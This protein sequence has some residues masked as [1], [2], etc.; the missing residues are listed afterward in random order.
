MAGDRAR[1]DITYKASSLRAHLSRA[2][3]RAFPHMLRGLSGSVRRPSWSDSHVLL[4][5]TLGDCAE[6]TEVCRADLTVQVPSGMGVR[7]AV[8][9]H[10]PL[11]SEHPGQWRGR[12]KDWPSVWPRGGL[13]SLQAPAVP[14]EAC[15]VELAPPS[16]SGRNIFGQ[17]D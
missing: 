10:N 13:Q 15:S 1:G 3:L 8:V 14:S 5:E 12:S 11:Q 16:R 17:N 6:V 2:H 9:A 7:N 4:Q